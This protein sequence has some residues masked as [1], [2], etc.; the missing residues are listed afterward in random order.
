MHENKFEECVLLLPIIHNFGLN[1]LCVKY[2]ELQ[3]M[4][5]TEY[6]NRDKQLCTHYILLQLCVDS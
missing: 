3:I 5:Q 6:I 1:L 2:G 4:L